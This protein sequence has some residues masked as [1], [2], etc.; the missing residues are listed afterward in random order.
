MAPAPLALAAALIAAGG[1]GWAVGG[2]S[3]PSSE[4][5]GGDLMGA[6]ERDAAADA[7]AEGGARRDGGARADAAADAASLRPAASAAVRPP[8]EGSCVAIEGQPD[9]E[10]RRT[11]GRPACRGAQVLEW[12]DS[13]G[14]PRYA[15][16]YTPSGVETRAP[17]PLV[18]F[19]HAEGD[20]PTS[21]EKET[22]LRKLGATLNM[23]GDPA[24][25]GFIVLALQGRS[26]QRGKLGAIFDAG[27]TGPDNVDVAAVDHFTGELAARGLVDKARVYALGA[28]HGGHMAAT[29]AMMRADRVAAFATYGSDAPPATWSCPG[30]PPPAM[31]VYR[32][33]D[34]VFPCDSVERWLRAR[35]AIAAETSSLRLDA[36]AREEPNCALK[37]RCSTLKGSSQ[38]G[39]WPKPREPDILRF[40]AGHALA[41]PR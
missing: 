7:A 23:T 19:F 29:Y 37:N 40:L 6:F 20:S 30:P 35:D 32:A 14:A 17:L 16:A 33:C 24:H 9:R 18:L 27:Y 21:V 13:E 36:A 5:D 38:H 25:A 8:P 26:L 15:C 28:S 10:I 12:R 39:R 1:A 11:L 31:V 4:I 3:T 22:G 34:A 41:V 2:C